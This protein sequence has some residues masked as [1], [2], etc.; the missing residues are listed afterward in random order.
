MDY[1]PQYEPYNPVQ[2][3][4][5][6]GGGG[7]ST[8]NPNSLVDSI[9]S[10]LGPTLQGIGSIIYATK[11]DG[12]QGMPAYGV[13]PITYPTTQPATTNNNTAMYIGI[14]VL[15]LLIVLAAAY[16]LKK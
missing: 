7:S 12:T 15:V 1:G 3:T 8:F 9:F 10:S 11:N 14:V 4:N 5:T 6:F 2:T 13:Q 16:F